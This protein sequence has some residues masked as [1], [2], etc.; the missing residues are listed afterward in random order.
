[1]TSVNKLDLV[2]DDDFPWP[3]NEGKI[4]F[5]VLTVLAACCLPLTAFCCWSASKDRDPKWIKS[6]ALE[7]YTGCL[8]HQPN[9]R[10]ICGAPGIILV[11]SGLATLAAWCAQEQ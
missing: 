2:E 7:R 5:I 11:I 8:K 6:G 1:M 4:I 10:F 9:D 3:Y